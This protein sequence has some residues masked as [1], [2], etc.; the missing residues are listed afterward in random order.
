MKQ[1]RYLLDTCALLWLLSGDKR[2]KSFWEKHKDYYPDWAIS[3]DSLKEILY[4]KERKKLNLAL[5]YSQIIEALGDNN[6][7][8]CN[9]EKKDLDILSNLPFFEEHKDP[10]DRSIIAIAISR[11]RVMVT[12]DTEFSR[13]EKYGLKLLQI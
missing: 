11:K 10:N 3:M 8:I 5:T 13:Y 2:I 4:K 1:E 7:Q 6:L 9:F 12:S